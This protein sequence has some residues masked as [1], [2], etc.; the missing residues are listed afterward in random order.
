[1][2]IARYAALMRPPEPG[3]IPREGLLQVKFI[4]GVAPSGHH[5]YGWAEYDRY[6]TNEELSH[7]DMEYVHSANVIEGGDAQ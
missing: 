7:Y 5:A 2:L 4:E 6:L 1:M 3:G